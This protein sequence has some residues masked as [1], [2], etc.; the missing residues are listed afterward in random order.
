MN[1]NLKINKNF[2][3]KIWD[4]EN[5]LNL[6]FG[7]FEKFETVTEKY[8]QIASLCNVQ[9]QNK[10]NRAS[11]PSTFRNSNQKYFAYV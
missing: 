11:K 1:K 8:K 5:N 10:P 4:V 2:R 6:F 9:K 3:G 7:S